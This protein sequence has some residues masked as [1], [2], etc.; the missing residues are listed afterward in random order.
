MR[1]AIDSVLRKP[2]ETGAIP[3]VAALAADDQGIFY[4]GAFGRRAID[5]PETMTLDSVFRI[6]SMT[7]AITA[8]AAMQ[9]VERGRGSTPT[10]RH[11]CARRSGR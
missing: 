11:D 8:T 9:L 6:A 1:A 3:G 2:I 7:K 5:K 4:E 10:V